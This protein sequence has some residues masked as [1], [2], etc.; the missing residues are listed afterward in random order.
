MGNRSDIDDYVVR[1]AGCL[2]FQP[3][4]D[5]P[6]LLVVHRPRYDDWSFAKGKL[7]PGETDLECARREVEEETGI[8]GLIGPELPTIDYVDNKGRPKAVRYWVLRATAGADVFEANDEVDEVRW[9]RPSAAGS[10]LSYDHDRALV[11]AFEAIDGAVLEALA[12]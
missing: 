2:V 10:L 3:G 7:D 6:E 8:T 11:A 9:L 1:A 5:G 12:G 4:A